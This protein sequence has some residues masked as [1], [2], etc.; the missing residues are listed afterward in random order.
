MEL[1]KEDLETLRDMAKK[2]IEEEQKAE[3]KLIKSKYRVG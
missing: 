1:E 3:E 2:K